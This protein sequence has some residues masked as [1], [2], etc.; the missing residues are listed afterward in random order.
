ALM[1][2]HAIAREDLAGRLHL[3]SGRDRRL[4]MAEADPSGRIAHP[5]RDAVIAAMRSRAI[6]LVVV[7]PFVKSHALDENDNGHMHAATTVRA[8]IAEATGAAVLLVHHLRK[9]SATDIDAAR[10]AKSL[11]DAARAA[12]LL[13]PMTPAEAEH[14]GI[15]AAER[16]RLVRR[17]DAKANL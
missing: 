1:R 4:V 11:T 2:A 12:A 3:H 6:G 5:D 14:L 8:D 17:E 10:G 16:W 13:T 9:G 15:A 7:D